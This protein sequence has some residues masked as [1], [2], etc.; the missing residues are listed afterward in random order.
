MQVAAVLLSVF[1]PFGEFPCV[2]RRSGLGFSPP[3]CVLLSFVGLLMGARFWSIQV[4][5]VVVFR[6]CN[7]ELES[8]SLLGSQ[9][10]KMAPSSRGVS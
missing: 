6:L 8:C 9:F 7:H 1:G 4:A 5:F 2:V 3:S 10:E